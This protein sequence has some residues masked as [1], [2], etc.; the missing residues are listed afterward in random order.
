MVLMLPLVEQE[1]MKRNLGPKK[2]YSHSNRNTSMGSKESKARTMELN[3]R[4]SNKESLEFFLYLIGQ[5][6]IF[7]YILKE[8]IK[9]PSLYFAK[10]KVVQR[11]GQLI[12][13]ND[14]RMLLKT[15]GS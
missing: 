1:E 2:G 6:Q 15:F 14:E 4:K 9:I 13:V 10:E 5:R 11:D 7:K 8:N 12:M 3:M